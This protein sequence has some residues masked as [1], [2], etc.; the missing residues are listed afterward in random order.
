MHISIMI[1]ARASPR[2]APLPLRLPSQVGGNVCKLELV[3]EAGNCVNL[4]LLLA[5]LMTVTVSNFYNF[6]D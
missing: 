4:N 2:A 1:I 5:R 3:L 6:E